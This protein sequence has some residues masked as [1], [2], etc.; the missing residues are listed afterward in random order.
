VCEKHVKPK[1][2]ATG[3]AYSKLVKCLAIHKEIEDSS[4]DGYE[5]CSTV[6]AVPRVYNTGNS[7]LYGVVYFILI[8]SM[9]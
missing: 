3:Q 1:K 6:E 4:D 9:D 7:V 5:E 8:Q 2:E